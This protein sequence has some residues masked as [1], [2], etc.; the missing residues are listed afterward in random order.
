MVK[1]HKDKIIWAVLV[2]EL[3]HVFCCVLPIV[4][5]VM[6]VLSG[7]GIVASMPAGLVWFH[8]VMHDY[9]L[10]MIGVSGLILAFGWA[11]LWYSRNNDC[12][13]VSD[14]SHAPCGPRKSLTHKILIGA[15]ILFVINVS[16]YTLIH[17]GADAGVS[18]DA[19]AGHEG[20]DDH[21]GHGH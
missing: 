7:F 16:V 15:S 6:S 21:A 3:G 14:C 1:R 19:H 4:F 9:E 18:A 8:D 20:H 13:E 2:S 17:R 12:H 10:P 11:A 5:S